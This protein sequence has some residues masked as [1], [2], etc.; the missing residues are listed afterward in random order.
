MTTP[1]EQKQQTAQKFGKYIIEKELGRGGMGIVYKA[2]DPQLHRHIALKLIL[3]LEQKNIDRFMKESKA[4]AQITHPNLVTIYECG[5]DPQ[6]YFAMEY[7]EGSTLQ[8]L[9]SEKKTKP[10]FVVNTMIKICDCLQMMHEKNIL[11][12]DI[13]PANIMIDQANEPKVMDLGL[14][15]FIQTDSSHSTEDFMGTPAYMSPE[16]I[17]GKTNKTSDVYA[18]GVTMYEALTHQKMFE[19]DS[20]TNLLY[21]IVRETPVPPGKINPK[22]A[23]QIE[24]ICLKCVQKDS[25]Q[26]YQNCKQLKKALENFKKAR[27]TQRTVL[28]K[29][30][31]YKLQK[32]TVAALGVL[33]LLSVSV[34]FFFYNSYKQLKKQHGNQHAASHDSTSQNNDRDNVVVAKNTQE[35]K[36]ANNNVAKDQNA[37]PSNHHKENTTSYSEKTS[38]QNETAKRYFHQALA[39]HEQDQPLKAIEYFSRAIM[40]APRYEKAYSNRGR[41][42]LNQGKV[43]EALADFDRALTFNKSAAN[44]YDKAVALRKLQQNQQALTTLNLALELHDQDPRYWQ[45]RSLLH[46]ALKNVNQALSDIDRAIQLD[47]TNAQ[48]YSNKG[49]IYLYQKKYKEALKYLNKAQK[50][51]S[52]LDNVYYYKGEIYYIHKKYKKALKYFQRATK[53]NKKYAVAY[54]KIGDCCY[55]VAEYKVAIFSWNMALKCGYPSRQETLRKIDLAKQKMK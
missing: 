3:N 41:I 9:I 34:S 35:N 36:T 4:L 46:Y 22:V 15:K 25:K 26:R 40:H 39:F 16:Q 31:E 13:K 11:H 47:K 23:P 27:K 42:Y 38:Q 6:P 52:E 29:N 14:A 55:R 53:L 10:F 51:N 20:S 21:K 2:Y 33:L 54:S 48:H 44:F 45:L 19:A 37:Q 1:F 7:I 8:D 43:K 32:L 28:K 49:A 30:Q 12:R 50:L 17:A 18:L 24:K 5:R